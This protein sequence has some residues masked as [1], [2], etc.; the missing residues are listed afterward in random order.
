MPGI[1]K[2]F[3]ETSADS[4]VLPK[5]LDLVVEEPPP[6][7]EETPAGD[8]A[9]EDGEA[10]D[11][12]EEAAAPE[13][14]PLAYARIQAEAVMEDARQE[15]EAYRQDALKKLEAELEEQRAAARD[16]GYAEGYARGMSA[17]T[18][19]AMKERA[20]L[21]AEQVKEVQNFLEEAARI[22]DQLFDENREEMKDLALAVAEKVIKVSLQNSGD[23]LLRMVDAATDTH[24]RCEWARIYVAACDVKGKAFTVPELAASLK[25]I[26]DRVRVVPM[27]D[28]ESGTCIVE[29]PDVIL[30]ASVSTQLQ[31][32]RDVLDS[33]GYDTD[34]EPEALFGSNREALESLLAEQTA[35]DISAAEYPTAGDWAVKGRIRP[36][37]EDEP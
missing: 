14:D 18:E 16:A 11:T 2:H 6:P 13:E 10:V 27:D 1:L 23:I 33:T 31:N 7:E 12:A 19:Q 21:A 30:D 36:A 3:L 37:G 20:A 25:H 15:A 24:K 22:R 8:A 5:V 34:E 26:S 28:D 4:Y 32:I 35:K 17:A 9:P 29:T